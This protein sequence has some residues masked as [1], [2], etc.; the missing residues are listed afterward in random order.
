LSV[1]VTLAGI[2]DPV[3]RLP[4]GSNISLGVGLGSAAGSSSAI[5]PSNPS[6]FAAFI[7]KVSS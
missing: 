6:S 4:P 7:P 1:L 2:E 3:N 5:R